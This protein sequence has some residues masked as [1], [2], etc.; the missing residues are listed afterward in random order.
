MAAS[1]PYRLS[2][3]GA[4]LQVEE[5]IKIAQLYADLKDWEAVQAEVVV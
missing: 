5:S 3:S 2:F 4:A 1:R